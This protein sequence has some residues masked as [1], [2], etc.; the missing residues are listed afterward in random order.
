MDQRTSVLKN[1]LAMKADP[2]NFLQ[3][4]QWQTAYEKGSPV[5]VN[6]TL[7]QRHDPF[8]CMVVCE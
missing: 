7:R 5:V 3:L 2:L 1:V 8:R 6:W 4:M